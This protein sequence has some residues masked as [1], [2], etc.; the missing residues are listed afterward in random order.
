MSTR[1]RWPLA[2]GIVLVLAV[3]ARGWW[4]WHQAET[5][6][7]TE[8]VHSLEGVDVEYVLTPG[9]AAALG[10]LSGRD[11]DVEPSGAVLMAGEEGLLEI[12]ATGDGVDVDRLAVEVPDSFAL[13]GQ[14][15]LLSIR[16]QY[17]GQLEDGRFSQAVPLPYPTMRLMGS[18]LAGAAYVIGGEDVSARRVY[19]YFADGTLQIECEIPDEVVAVADDSA[20]VYVASAHSLFRLTAD[21]L[22][23]VANLPDSLGEIVSLAVTPDDRLLF[24]STDQTTFVMSGLAAVAI[25]QDLGGPIRFRNGRLYVWSPAREMLVALSGL[26][27][28]LDKERA[29][30]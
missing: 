19:G 6:A 4:A 18:S 12:T 2:A 10:H 11:F 7:R 29:E 16:G 20:A 27:A 5:G 9:R 23:V 25:V 22:D 30:P 28:R 13:D 14:G 3:T 8:A 24:F 21:R 26:P 17:F 1:P 15:A